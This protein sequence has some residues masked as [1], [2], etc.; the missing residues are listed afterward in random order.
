MGRP[1]P[2]PGPRWKGVKGIFHPLPPMNFKNL[3]IIVCRK[4]LEIGMF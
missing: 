4:N 1:N 3:I 2:K